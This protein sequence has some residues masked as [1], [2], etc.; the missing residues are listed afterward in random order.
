MFRPPGRILQLIRLLLIK[1]Y[2]RAAAVGSLIILSTLSPAILPASLVACLWLSLKYAGTV[3]TAS[4]TVDPRK[5][6]AAC[7]SFLKRLQNG[8]ENSLCFQ[9]VSKHLHSY[10]DNFIRKNFSIFFGF[11]KSPSY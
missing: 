6:S 9:P 1:P 8:E 3:I 4:E 7:L 2:A 11:F 5:D 10:F